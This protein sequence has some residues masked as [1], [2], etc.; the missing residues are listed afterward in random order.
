MVND[1]YQ[2]KFRYQHIQVHV[3]IHCISYTNLLFCYYKD[4]LLPPRVRMVNQE[5]YV[6]KSMQNKEN[7]VHGDHEELDRCRGSGVKDSPPVYDVP[8]DRDWAWV[9]LFSKY[10]NVCISD[11]FTLYL[12]SF[13]CHWLCCFLSLALLNPRFD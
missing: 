12:F 11:N 8:V 3:C 1:L 2:L 5:T 9:I 10:I 4:E 13:F 7:R 6:N